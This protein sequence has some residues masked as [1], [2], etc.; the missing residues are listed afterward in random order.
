MVDFSG[1]GNR[2]GNPTNITHF[3]VGIGVSTVSHFLNNMANQRVALKHEN[4][5]DVTYLDRAMQA[6][7]LLGKYGGGYFAADK[8]SVVVADE[9]IHDLLLEVGKKAASWAGWINDER[10]TP[11]PEKT[12]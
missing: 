7:T 12:V 2:I 9:H 1:I 5:I 11:P 10:N 8:V 6:T 4:Q 3:F